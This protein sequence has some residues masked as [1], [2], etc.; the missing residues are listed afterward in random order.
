MFLVIAFFLIVAVFVGYNI[1]QR[2]AEVEEHDFP[3]EIQSL[4]QNVSS[5]E[6]LQK[7]ISYSY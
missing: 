5:M 4:N 3:I 6:I 1:S 7:I 2:P